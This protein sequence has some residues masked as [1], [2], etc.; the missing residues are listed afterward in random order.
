MEAK[1]G[2]KPRRLKSPNFDWH[3]TRLD[4][5]WGR[6]ITSPSG[7]PPTLFWSRSFELWSLS[8]ARCHG[9]RNK[10][11]RD[12]VWWNAGTK[13]RIRN[14]KTKKKKRT[15]TKL[16]YRS[17]EGRSSSRRSIKCQNYGEK[18]PESMRNA[19]IPFD[20]INVK[21]E[22]NSTIHPSFFEN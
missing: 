22:G 6:W 10:Q 4:P 19:N 20:N 7:H 21:K 3:L 12:L 2:P 1:G 8:A 18:T 9:E 5:W 17:S 15:T 14:S 11:K 16:S 13:G